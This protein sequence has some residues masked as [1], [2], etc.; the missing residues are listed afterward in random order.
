MRIAGVLTILGIISGILAMT[1][2]G[3]ARNP[4]VVGAKTGGAA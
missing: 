1:L 4:R 2:I 3:K